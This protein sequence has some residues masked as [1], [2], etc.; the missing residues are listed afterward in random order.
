MKK[1]FVTLAAVAAALSFVSC[2]KETTLPTEVDLNFNI[3]VEDLTTGPDT[4]ALKPGWEDGDI[5]NIWFDSNIG[6]TPNMTL[7]R[8]SGSWVASKVSTS[9][10]ES[11]KS[12][13]GNINAM[14]EGTNNLSKTFTATT[15]DENTIRFVPK[16][17]AESPMSR[18]LTSRVNYTY[19]SSTKTVSSPSS[20]S[21]SNYAGIQITVPGVSSGSWTISS[22][23]LDALSYLSMNGN[24]SW[25]MT[26]AKTAVTPIYGGLASDGYVFVGGQLTFAA[27][28]GAVAYTFTLT[29]GA[30]T[31]SY[32]SAEVALSPVSGGSMS[33]GFYAVILPELQLESDG[34]VSAGCK[35][36][37]S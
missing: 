1:I 28:T 6:A 30:N 23:Y 37:K 21:F 24:A 3:P 12:T 32:T 5:I 8:Q 22:S 35:W 13:G 17:T 20:I 34:T 14:W 9:V 26:T 11:L 36:I 4:K 19:D 33:Y 27:R 10:I 29:N 25:Q 18:I 7:T 2:E 31:Y 16:N 15:Y